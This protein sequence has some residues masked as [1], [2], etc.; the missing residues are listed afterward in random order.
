MSSTPAPVPT[1]R[2]HA[3]RVMIYA[4]LALALALGAGLRLTPSAGAQNT[5]STAPAMVRVATVDV[6]A[7]AE[8]L[9]GTEKYRFGR[10]TN[11]AS[12]S[13]PLQAMLDELKGLETKFNALPADSAER[14]PLQQQFQQK[15]TAFQ[16]AQ[17]QAQSDDEKFKAT[18]VAEAYRL[19]VEA[20]DKLGAE[21]GY[22]IILCTRNGPVAIR[23]DNVPGAVQEM[24]ARPVLR[25]PASDDLTDRVA[26]ALGLSA[27]PASAEPV[28][29]Q[30]VPA[31][32]PKP[33]GK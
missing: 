5:P 4:G 22:T 19:V 6:L 33:A 26:K 16:Q 15:N 17:Q 7:L 11:A 25:G 20:A 2:T 31:E 24:L 29:A 18:Q 28:K 8:R 3:E 27:E 10:E 1:F 14:A 12:L 32:T 30:A 9:V 13:K 23:S 21:L